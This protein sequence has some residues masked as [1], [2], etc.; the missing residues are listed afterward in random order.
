MSLMAS[1]K[2]ESKAAALLTVLYGDSRDL[3]ELLLPVVAYH[4]VQMV[5][6]AALAAPMRAAALR[7]PP[8]P[9]DVESVGGGAA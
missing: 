8:K 2:T 5:V 7:G 6:A 3:G 1:Q 4:S 9:G